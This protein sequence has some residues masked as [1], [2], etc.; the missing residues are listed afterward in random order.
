ML[1]LKDSAADIKKVFKSTVAFHGMTA[2]SSHGEQLFVQWLV[3]IILIEGKDN[4]A[5]LSQSFFVILIVAS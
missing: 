5:C 4:S 2:Y 1:F 3:R